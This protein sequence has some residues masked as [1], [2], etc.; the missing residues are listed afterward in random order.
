MKKSIISLTEVFNSGKKIAFIKGNRLVNDKN[1]TSKKASFDKFK[2]NLI[3]LMYVS[4]EKATADGCT[5]IDATTDEEVNPENAS[6]Y[7]AIV[8]GQHRFTAAMEA[9]LDSDNL[10]LFECY[11]DSDTKELIAST[12]I[13]SNPWNSK[14]YVYGAVM[15][16]PQNELAQMANKM[17]DAGYPLSTIG[18]ILY[19]ASGKLGKKDLSNI[20]QGKS[21][22]DGY[23][24]ERAEY[25]MEKAHKRFDDAFIGKKYLISAVIDL[26]TKKGYEKVCDVIPMLSDNQ[27]KRIL[28]SKSDDKIPI[29]KTALQNQ[30]DK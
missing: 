17:A 2:M 25:F 14:D 30:L 26:S 24:L 16:N 23:D 19:F 10:Y 11:S 8:D 18:L 21:A 9:E 27:V 22:K 15:F 1:V 28:E 7:I 4:G 12:N 29:I 13:D 6:E 5:L 3:P 20:M